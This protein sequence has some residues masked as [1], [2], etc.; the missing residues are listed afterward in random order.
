M[1]EAIRN[2]LGGVPVLDAEMSGPA[3]VVDFFLGDFLPAIAVFDFET[4][5]L[6][7]LGLEWVELGGELESVVGQSVNGESDHVLTRDVEIDHSFGPSVLWLGVF[8]WGV[9][10]GI[11]FPPIGGGPVIQIG[12]FIAENFGGSRHE[13]G[14]GRSNSEE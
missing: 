9:G 11:T 4:D 7:F 1:A 10:R 3:G 5:D 8:L 12:E 6:G 13:L 2:V 14:G